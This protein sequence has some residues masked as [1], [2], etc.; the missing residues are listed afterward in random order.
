MEKI[1]I[2]ENEIEGSFA[3]G[4]VRRQ[5]P[6]IQNIVD[7]IMYLEIEP[8]TELLM[9]ALFGDAD[10][11]TQTIQEYLNSDINRL[12]IKTK[13]LRAILQPSGDFLEGLKKAVENAKDEWW[14]PQ[15]MAYLKH[16][17]VS[18]N[19]VVLDEAGEHSIREMHR[20]YIRTKKGKELRDAHAKAWE[21]LNAFNQM[22][23]SSE[24]GFYK[25]VTGHV[26]LWENMARYFKAKENGEIE[27]NVLDYDRLAFTPEA[28]AEQE[29]EPEGFE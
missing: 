16:I 13:P 20:I 28:V 19:K 11:V 4:A 22:L 24:N 5:L 25:S 12:K 15:L 1:L 8:S 6:K 21:A 27:P 2:F 9:D 26:R 18:K 3:I 10:K 14:T 29:P 17:T 7:E 23:L